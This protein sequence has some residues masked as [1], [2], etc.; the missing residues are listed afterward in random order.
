LPARV[1]PGMGEFPFPH[2]MCHTALVAHRT[3]I[4][5]TERVG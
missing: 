4:I 1:V 5:I 3:V 2:Q